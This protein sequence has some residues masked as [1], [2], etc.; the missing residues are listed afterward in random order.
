MGTQ[1][2]KTTMKKLLRIVTALISFVLALATAPLPGPPL[3]LTFFAVSLIL[4]SPDFAFINSFFEKII[5]K[6]PV[7]G[8]RLDKLRN[9]VLKRF[10]YSI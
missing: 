2:T 1:N 9:S 8:L 7:F 4:L 5:N 3:G 10:D 6:Y